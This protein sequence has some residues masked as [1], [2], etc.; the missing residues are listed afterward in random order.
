ML[1]SVSKTT[2]SVS[3]PVCKGFPVSEQQTNISDMG[4][5]LRNIIQPGLFC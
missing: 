2:V 3:N 4:T 1:G 5:P